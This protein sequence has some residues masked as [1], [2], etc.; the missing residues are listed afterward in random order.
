HEPIVKRQQSYAP[1]GVR[2]RILLFKL[3]RE[4]VHRRLRLREAD[5]GLEPPDDVNIV[6]GAIRMPGSQR[7]IQHQRRPHLRARRKLEAWGMDAPYR[8]AL[9]ANLNLTANQMRVGAEVSLP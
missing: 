5:A 9:A 1:S 8:V 6:M 7:R 2:F 4:D 3:A